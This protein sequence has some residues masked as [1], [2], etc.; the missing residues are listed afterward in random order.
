MFFGRKSEKDGGNDSAITSVIGQDMQLEGDVSFKGKL[1]LD[2]R[3]KGN[4]QGDY[5]IMGESGVVVGDIL[6]NTFVCCGQVEGKVN[7]KKLNVFASGAVDGRVEATDMTVESG[8]AL[9]GE[10]KS[11][12]KELRLEPGSSISKEDRNAQVKEAAT[13]KKAKT[14]T[15][16]AA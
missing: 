12:S 4:V 8:A 11:R 10:V 5:L 6:V 9:N 13:S 3:I 7:V 2:G 1:R 16:N 15:E 14:G